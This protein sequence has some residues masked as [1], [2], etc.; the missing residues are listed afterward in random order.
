MRR[1]FARL[2]RRPEPSVF[3]VARL[4]PLTYAMAALILVISVI[5]IFA[6]IVAP[7]QIS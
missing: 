6:D 7:V 3:D 4:L 2:F 1:G 5:L